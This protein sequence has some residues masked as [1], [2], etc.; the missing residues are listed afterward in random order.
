MKT[1]TTNI[2]ILCVLVGIVIFILGGEMAIEKRLRQD[3][4]KMHHLEVDNCLELG[5]EVNK[6]IQMAFQAHMSLEEFE[7]QF[8]N[9]EPIEQGAYPEAKENRTHVYVHEPSHRVFFLRF[10]NEIL[11]GYTSNFSVDDIQPH[12]PS[13]EERIEAL[14]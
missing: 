13:I 4:V 9:V 11:Q 6:R 8:G 2:L 7:N 1:K 10:E 3:A 12:L 14:R 5:Q